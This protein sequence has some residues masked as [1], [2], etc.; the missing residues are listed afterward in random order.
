MATPTHTTAEVDPT[1]APAVVV[2]QDVE[3]DQ[4][5]DM[6][7][8]FGDRAG[9]STTSLTQSIMEY[10]ELHG[11]TY[12]NLGDTYYW[13]PNDEKQNEQLD[14]GHHMLTMLLDNKLFLAPIS[15]NPQNVLDVGTGTGI[16]A[17]DF[18]DAFPSSQVTGTDLSPIQPSFIPPN[19]KFE[20]DDAQMDWTFA[21]DS[22]DYVHMR[23][24]M[25]SIRDWQRLYG[26]VYNCTKPGGYIESMEMD[27][28]FLS[29]D[30]TVKEG[31]VMYDWSTLF[32]ESGEQIGQT[33][34]IPRI[35]KS[36]IEAAGFVDVVETKY[37]LPVGPWMEDPK[38]KDLGRW[39][40]LYL[41]E[42]LEGMVMFVLLKIMGWSYEEMAVYVGNMRKALRSSKNHGYYEIVVVYG[43]KPEFKVV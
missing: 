43:R 6:D 18:A 30:G 3:E 23:C 10:R 9:S 20:I 36:L 4:P 7:S 8:L 19:L 37:K 15:S 21:P 41:D 22:F 31:D 2:G 24:L 12:H 25:G 27:I 1:Q 5:Q 13:G 35:A 14:I 34:K 33:F 32:I 39:N 28:Q 16:W 29:D 38:W 17:I 26:Q 42:G 11:R 40:L